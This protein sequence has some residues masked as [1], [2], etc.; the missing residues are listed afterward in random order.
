MSNSKL[1]KEFNC[2]Q[3]YICPIF[4]G[5]V[6]KRN[7]IVV[8]CCKYHRYVLLMYTYAP[9]D[10]CHQR[11]SDTEADSFRCVF[12]KVY[13]KQNKDDKSIVVLCTVF[14]PY[15]CKYFYEEICQKK[16]Y[17]KFSWTFFERNWYIEANECH[18]H[19]Y[20]IDHWNNM[21]NWKYRS[22]TVNSK[23]FVGKVLLRIK[24]K[25]ELN[26]TL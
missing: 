8:I 17:E 14:P 10:D 22:G 1:D 13:Q 12:R 4:L 7:S 6:Q 5:T 25:F 3:I 11:K 23:S 19:E 2:S 20:W 24:W 9:T 16:D 21:I 15:L 26:Y 18:I